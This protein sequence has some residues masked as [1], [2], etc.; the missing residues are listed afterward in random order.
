VAKLDIATLTQAA[1]DLLERTAP[2]RRRILEN[3]HRHVLGRS[4]TPA[5]TPSSSRTNNSPWPT[6]ASH[7]RRSSSPMPAVTSF[8]TVAEA[9]DP[10]IRPL[11]A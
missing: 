6:G 4:A 2:H 8:I 9:R 7:R 1:D 3:H 5:R 11:P 10:L